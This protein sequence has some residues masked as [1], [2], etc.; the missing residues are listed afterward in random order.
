MADL[1]SDGH[2]ASFAQLQDKHSIPNS[3]LFRYLKI[4]HYVKQTF[5]HFES[6]PTTHPFYDN[7]QLAPDSKHLISRFVNC[8]STSV[9]TG[10]LRVAWAQDLN[11][12]VS[13]ELW[14]KAVSL[15]HTCC[16]NSCYR[17]IQYKV[18]HRLHYSKTKLNEMFPGVSSQCEKCSYAEGTL[19]HL[20]R[21]CHQLFGFWLKFLYSQLSN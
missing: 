2:F 15:I 4:R 7:L 18:V 19:A 20:F 16:I 12:E 6:F 1:Y 21:F 5:E 10:H 11:S 3:H 17:L 8:F 14:D 13:Y 9:S